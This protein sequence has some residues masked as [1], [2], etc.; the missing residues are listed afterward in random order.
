MGVGMFDKI[1]RDRIINVTSTNNIVLYVTERQT[2]FI[3][4][5]KSVDSDIYML[6]PA[7]LTCAVVIYKFKD[8][9]GN[10]I[11]IALQHVTGDYHCPIAINDEYNL[12]S[13]IQNT[14][15]IIGCAISN[16]DLEKQTAN[17]ILL[18]AGIL[19]NN[20]TFIWP[21]GPGMPALNS[22]AFG[23]NSRGEYGSFKFTSMSQQRIN[24]QKLYIYDPLKFYD[25]NSL[26]QQQL[27]QVS[28][29]QL[30]P[31]LVKDAKTQRR[32]CSSCCNRGGRCTCCCT[33]L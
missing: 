21:I 9:N 4:F 26:V 7:V 12:G 22:P 10:V 33:I 3:K 30:T 15:I 13:Y 19:P 18:P 24:L 28:S 14:E 11:A 20:I 31:L 32:S 25:V 29:T 6:A 27:P 23:V 16:L 8:R 1:E 17:K 5:P 2:A